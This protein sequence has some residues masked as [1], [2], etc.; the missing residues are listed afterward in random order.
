MLFGKSVT[1]WPVF[2][3]TPAALQYLRRYFKL[4]ILSNADRESF[5][6]SNRRFGV[7]FDIILTAQSNLQSSVWRKRT[8]FIPRRVCFTIMLQPQPW[9]S[10]RRG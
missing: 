6:S 8:F 5:A 7:K 3:D 4:A 1:H 9:E 10:P 2:A